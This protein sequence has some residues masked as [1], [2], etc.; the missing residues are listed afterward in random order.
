MFRSKRTKHF[1]IA[2]LFRK[3][4]TSFEVSGADQWM[5]ATKMPPALR[6]RRGQYL[7]SW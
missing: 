1:V 2:K 3:T 4:V 7:T 6:E 5:V